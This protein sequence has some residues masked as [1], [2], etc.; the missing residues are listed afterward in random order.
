MCVCVCVCVRPSVCPSVRLS[1]GCLLQLNP[2]CRQTFGLNARAS[3]TLL[4]GSRGLQLL[5][6]FGTRY[7]TSAPRLCERLLLTTQLVPDAGEGL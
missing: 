2:L 3:L 4:C 6:K 7:C 5:V 1:G